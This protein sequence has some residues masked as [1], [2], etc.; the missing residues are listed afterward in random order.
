MDWGLLDKNAGENKL[1]R[2]EIV[3]AYKVSSIGS[4]LLSIEHFFN[5]SLCPWDRVLDIMIYE[6]SCILL[7]NYGF[8]FGKH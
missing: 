1:L 2:E 3:Y 7:L 4:D 5:V 8:D 6:K